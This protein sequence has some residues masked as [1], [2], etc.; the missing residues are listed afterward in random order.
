MLF[1]I[2]RELLIDFTFLSKF[3]FFTFFSYSKLN[4][5]KKQKHHVNDI[6]YVSADR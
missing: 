6:I 3:Y 4:K 1:A 5:G 2:I